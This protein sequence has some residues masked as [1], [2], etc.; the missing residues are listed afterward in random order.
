MR[1]KTAEQY[2]SNG[3]RISFVLLER[4]AKA[5]FYYYVGM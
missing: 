4:S 5:W 3:D 1:T 2:E